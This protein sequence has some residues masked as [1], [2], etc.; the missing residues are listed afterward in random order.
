MLS[1]A[2]AA[3]RLL[4]NNQSRNSDRRVTRGG[5]Q[6]TWQIAAYSASCSALTLTARSEGQEPSATL[7]AARHFANLAPCLTYSLGGGRVSGCWRRTLTEGG[8]PASPS[9]AELDGYHPSCHERRT[10]CA[11]HLT[12][13][14][15][16]R[17]G[18][19]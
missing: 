4:E 17:A 2:L 1:P 16:M 11:W 8:L 5:S 15:R 7:S 6:R 12:A 10:V 19:H 13:C 14:A 9:T 18:G 3:P